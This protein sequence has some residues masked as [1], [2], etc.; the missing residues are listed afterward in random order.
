MIK[1]FIYSLIA[2]VLALVVTLYLGFPG[3]P[4]YL[5]FAFGTY[6]FETSLFALLVASGVIYLVV[7]LLLIVFNSNNATSDAMRA[8]RF[9]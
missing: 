2:I 6:T 8:V 5:L 1:L 7:K 4:G 9:E 3:D